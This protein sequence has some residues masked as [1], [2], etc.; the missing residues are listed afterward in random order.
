MS[1]DGL[2]DVNMKRRFF[3]KQETRWRAVLDI[4]PTPRRHVDAR[5][6]DGMV[7]VKNLLSVCKMTPC[8]R[9]A[10]VISSLSGCSA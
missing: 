3:P 7:R 8:A 9:P 5:V 6:R 4:Y 2:G 1:C 10:P